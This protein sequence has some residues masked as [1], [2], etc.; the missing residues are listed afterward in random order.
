[1]P[2]HA[3][4]WPIMLKAL[5]LE[6]P[7]CIL[8]HGWWLSAGRK[9]SKTKTDADLNAPVEKAALELAAEL[10]PDS[11]RHFVLRDMTVGQDADYSEA[12]YRARYDADLANNLGNLASRVQN[13]TERN[14]GGKVPL[15]PIPQEEPENTLQGAWEEARPA[16]IA[17]CECYRFSVASEKIFGF[18]KATNVYL[19]TR[20]PWKLAKSA[21][22]AAPAQILLTLATVAEALR[23]GSTLLAP[24]L[25]GTSEK[26]LAG[27]GQPAA[28]VWDAAVLAWNP[29]KLAGS[30]LGPKVILFPKPAPAPKGA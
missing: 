19:E 26:L 16:V 29:A 2:P 17:A 14:C 21:D 22:P 9:V 18:F 20:A 25:P 5:G 28:T 27:L 30:T 11:F 13:L 23:L 1:M 4:Y 10:G 8:A 15:S 7:R 3:V 6:P 24:L 12:A